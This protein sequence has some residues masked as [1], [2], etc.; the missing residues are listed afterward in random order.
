MAAVG[1]DWRTKCVSRRN[2]IIGSGAEVMAFVVGRFG[3]R[4]HWNWKC[5]TTKGPCW[6]GNRWLFAVLLGIWDTWNGPSVQMSYCHAFCSCSVG[7]PAGWQFIYQRAAAPRI[8]ES[9][10][11]RWIWWSSFCSFASTACTLIFFPS[12]L[13]G[14][15]CHWVNCEFIPIV[16][17]IE[18]KT[19]FEIENQF[20]CGTIGDFHAIVFSMRPACLGAV[21][22]SVCL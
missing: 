15:M 3:W 11:F 2:T 17:Y 13:P 18:Q 16:Q 9:M 4:H 22:G 5:P 1:Q 14:A 10:I 8:D 12:L 19:I 7:R 21:A 6:V 20:S